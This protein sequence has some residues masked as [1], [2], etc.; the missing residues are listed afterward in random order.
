MELVGIAGLYNAGKRH[1]WGWAM[2]LA[3]A[4]PWFVYAVLFDKPGF[5][6]MSLLWISVHTRNTIKW[7]RD[8]HNLGEVTMGKERAKA[9]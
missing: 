8:R 1:W 3:S 6:A 7:Y 5:A 2:V 9:R 4:I